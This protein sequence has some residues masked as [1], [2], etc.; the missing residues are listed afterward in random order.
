MK[1]TKH[2]CA[3]G[4]SETPTTS[5]D[6]PTSTVKPTPSDAA[7]PVSQGNNPMWSTANTDNVSPPLATNQNLGEW[8]EDL[9][10]WPATSA[11][12]VSFDADVFE[13]LLGTLDLSTAESD[14]Q[15]L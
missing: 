10:D 11:E 4:F 13:T 9:F 8:P 2:T 14:Y 7:P 12:P 6:K 1:V 3:H 15:Q 5:A